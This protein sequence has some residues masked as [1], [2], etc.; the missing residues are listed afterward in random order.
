MKN[1]AIIGA[2][3][4]GTALALVAARAGHH[5]RLWAHDPEIAATLKNQKQNKIYLSG[6]DLPENIYPTHDLPEALHQAE[7]V[8]TA[9]PSHVCREV[10]VEHAPVFTG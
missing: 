4:Y 1:I 5:V 6:F 8:I 10:Y 7:L 9:I 2:G 3:S